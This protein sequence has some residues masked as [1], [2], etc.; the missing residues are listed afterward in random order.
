M[1]I[2]RVYCKKNFKQNGL[3]F[4]EGKIY[5]ACRYD[6]DYTGCLEIFTARNKIA[7]LQ[8]ENGKL[9]DEHEK[10]FTLV[11]H[12]CEEYICKGEID[13][14]QIGNELW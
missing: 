7:R 2:K 8:I 6:D 12:C 5:E 9:I 4:K 11:R 3:N 1:T 14:L 13:M 10:Y